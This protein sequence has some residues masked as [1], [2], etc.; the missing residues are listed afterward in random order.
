MVS[1]NRPLRTLQW[2]STAAVAD[3][4]AKYEFSVSAT[5]TG[6]SVAFV[7]EDVVVRVGRVIGSVNYNIT[8]AMTQPLADSLVKTLVERLKSADAALP[9]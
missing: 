7:A 6:G 4:S 9:G 8:G 2:V 1:R 3:Q 5:G